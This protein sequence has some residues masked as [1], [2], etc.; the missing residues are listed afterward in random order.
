MDISKLLQDG[1]TLATKKNTSVLCSSLSNAFCEE[2][3]ITS[4][5]IG[6]VDNSSTYKVTLSNIYGLNNFPLHTD[7]SHFPIPPRWVILEYASLAHSKTATI[8]VDTFDQKALP[9]NDNIFNNEIYLV[10]GG[11]KSF[12]STIVN[13]NLH[14]VSIL[15]WNNLTMKKLN[16]LDNRSFDNLPFNNRTRI[17]WEPNQTLIFDNWRMLHGREAI[18]PNEKN[19]VFIRH[20][21]TP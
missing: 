9:A 14:K 18:K 19:R 15:R 2:Y 13:K 5:K 6:Q 4:Y 1:F 20:F 12:L 21:L 7:G 8:L 11:K 3:R 17:E 16:K 10:T